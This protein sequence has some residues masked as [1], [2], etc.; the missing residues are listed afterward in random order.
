[1][2]KEQYRLIFTPEPEGGYTVNV[3]AIRGCIT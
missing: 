3:P 1:M 2:K